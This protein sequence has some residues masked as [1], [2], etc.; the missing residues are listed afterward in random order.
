[1]FKRTYDKI[2]E[3][4]QSRQHDFTSTR[5]LKEATKKKDLKILI[6]CF[7]GTKK[8][9]FKLLDLGA[10]IGLTG[11]LTDSNRG[12]HLK[13]IIKLIPHD[14]IMI[15][16][17]A[18]YLLP[19]TLKTKPKNRRCEPMHLNEICEQV[20]IRTGKTKGFWAQNTT[21]NA[22]TFFSLGTSR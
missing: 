3:L 14:R 22:K 11:W 1:M 17:D 20:A 12:S 10:Y 4:L 9:A 18:P 15:E 5:V 19:R 6:H 7:T 2:N 13:D 16:T 21:K 8:F